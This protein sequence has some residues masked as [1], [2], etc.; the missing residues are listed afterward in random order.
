MDRARGEIATAGRARRRTGFLDQG[1]EA[2]VG[3][4]HLLGAIVVQRRDHDVV[5]LEVAVQQPGPVRRREPAPGRAQHLQH[6]HTAAAVRREPRAQGAAVDEFHRQPH[7]L[8]DHAGV[9]DRHDVG[10]VEP[11]QRPGLA[12][13]STA[14]LT[15]TGDVRAQQLD[16]DLAIEL[17]IVGQHDLTHAAATQPL[18]QAIAPQLHRPRA[19]GAEQLGARGLSHHRAADHVQRRCRQP[20]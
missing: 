6:R 4:A 2:E 12:R 17:G 1:R 7:L 13:E 15:T 11:R 10:V 16:R 9:V 3:H 5:G 19:R 8:A 14:R 18:Q 20:R